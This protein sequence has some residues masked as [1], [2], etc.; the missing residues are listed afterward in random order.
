MT[1]EIPLS[2]GYVALVDDSLFDELS[3]FKW[4]YNNGYA[5]RTT[6]SNGVAKVLK[7]HRFIM[8]LQP[9]DGMDVDHVN[10]NSLDNRIANLRICTHAENMRNQKAYKNAKSGFKGVY[11]Y[12]N[13]T[14][15][16]QI[17]INGKKKNLGYFETP[18][19]A[20][21]AYVAAAKELHGQYANTGTGS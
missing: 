2:R 16:A 3:K 21:A 19:K 18:E 6:R 10:G 5:A 14:W 15:T 7:M 8:N 11:R 4:H 9:D 13:R 20:H 12:K 17:Q 1:K